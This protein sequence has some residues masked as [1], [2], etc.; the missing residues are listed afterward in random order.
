M[1]QWLFLIKGDYLVLGW[2]ESKSKPYMKNPVG[3]LEKSGWIRT[4]KVTQMVFFDASLAQ[5]RRY[6]MKNI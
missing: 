6:I 2:F 3:L 1:S 4:V 5:A